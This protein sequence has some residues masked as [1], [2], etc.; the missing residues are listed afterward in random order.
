[1]G[2]AGNLRTFNAL[3]QERL[4]AWLSSVL[5]EKDQTEWQSRDM[6]RSAR[7]KTNWGRK[8]LQQKLLEVFPAWESDLRPLQHATLHIGPTNSGK[9]FQALNEL[10]NAGSGWY[11]SPLRLL[12]YEVFD[13]YP[14]YRHLLAF[15]TPHRKGWPGTFGSKLPD[16]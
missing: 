4:P 13:S 8:D 1:M 2:A 12:A 11:L 3:F 10:V 5:A 16:G 7:Y 6:D 9:T 14:I 15:N